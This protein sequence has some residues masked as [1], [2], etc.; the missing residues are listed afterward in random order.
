MDMKTAW[1]PFVCGK[2]LKSNCNCNSE[3]VDVGTKKKARKVELGKMS[4]SE[5]RVD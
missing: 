5:A 1:R 3:L 2:C 4:L